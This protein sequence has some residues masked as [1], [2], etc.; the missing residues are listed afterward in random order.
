MNYKT[1]AQAAVEWGISEQ[2]VRKLCRQGRIEGSIIDKELWLIPANAKKPGK[3]KTGPRPKPIEEI[4]PPKLLKKLI[5]QRDGRN[6][7][8]LYDYSQIN[9]AYSSCRMA[10]GRLTREQITLILQKDKILTYNERVKVNDII[11]ARNH[12]RAFDMILDVATEPLT[13]EFILSLHRQLLGDSCDHKRRDTV[14]GEFRTSVPKDDPKTFSKPT[15]ISA[16][17]SN[18]IRTYE[19][20]TSYSLEDI[21]GFHVHF[22]RITF[23]VFLQC[24]SFHTG[25]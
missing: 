2:Y 9:L 23:L 15:K 6:Y 5:H 20:R 12:L 24:P 19:S 13:P 8:G 14:T 10:S 17:L 16:D 25:S 3:S 18:L 7:S 21:L 4:S 1:S 11:E 22:E